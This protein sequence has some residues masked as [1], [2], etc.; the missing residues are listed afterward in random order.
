MDGRTNRFYGKYRGVVTDSTPDKYGGI[1]VICPAARGTTPMRAS[2]C[3]PYAGANVGFRFLPEKGAGVWVEFEGGD[4]SQP[5]WT[6]CYWHP[7]QFDRIEDPSNIKI[8][9][10]DKITIEID[11]QA[12]S[13]TIEHANGTVFKIEGTSITCSASGSITHKVGAMKTSLEAA[14]FDVHDG[15]MSVL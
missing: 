10:T 15:A 13:I 4:P 7:D 1:E 3:V 6:G 9:K 8:I 2:P 5:I 11:D 12:G 14:K